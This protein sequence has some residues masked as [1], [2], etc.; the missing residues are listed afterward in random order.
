MRFLLTTPA[1][2]AH[3]ELRYTA[4]RDVIAR[5]VAE[6]TGLESTDLLPAAAGRVTLALSLSAYEQWLTDDD[7]SLPDLLAAAFDALASLLTA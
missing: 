7:S 5:F 4:W 2:Q 3:S 1:L 6:R